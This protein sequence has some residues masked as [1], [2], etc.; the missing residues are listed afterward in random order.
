MSRVYWDSMIF[1]YVIE[2]NPDYFPIVKSVYENMARRG[3]TVLTSIFTLG[4]LLVGPRKLGSQS[5]VDRIRSY[6]ALGTVSILPF[7]FETSEQFA[8]IRSW[9]GASPSDAI[10]LAAAAEAQ[11][12]VLLTNDTKLLSLRIPGIAEIADL[13]PIRLARLL[14]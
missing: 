3:D 13:D 7:T 9:T 10:H 14:P 1:I 4:E 11:V 2:K 6:F 8:L 12:D 5:A